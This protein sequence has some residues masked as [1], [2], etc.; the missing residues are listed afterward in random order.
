META[1]KN[2]KVEISDLI[3]IIENKKNDMKSIRAEYDKFKLQ[4]FDE[5]ARLKMRG[6]IEN[7]NKAG[8]GDVFSK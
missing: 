4:A 5:M 1:I 7:I 3:D 6:K 8:L 2:Y